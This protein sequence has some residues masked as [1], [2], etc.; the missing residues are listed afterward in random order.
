MKNLMT[1]IIVAVIVIMAVVGS[2]CEEG[3]PVVRFVQGMQL[4]LYCNGGSLERL[5]V[6]DTDGDDEIYG[7]GFGYSLKVEADGVPLA[8]IKVECHVV[9]HSD[10]LD[11]EEDIWDKFAPNGE[12]YGYVHSVPN[13]SWDRDDGIATAYTN[14]HGKCIFLIGLGDPDV[15]F[16]EEGNVG[17]LWPDGSAG[18]STLVEVRFVIKRA[19]GN[20][21]S[22]CYMVFFRSQYQN[23]W[24]PYGGIYGASFSTLVP[25]EGLFPAIAKSGVDEET[26][27]GEL[28]LSET[29]LIR[30]LPYPGLSFDKSGDTSPLDLIYDPNCPYV[31]DPNC[32]RPNIVNPIPDPNCP[33]YI[34]DPDCPDYPDPDC[35]WIPDPNC[36]IPDP[37]CWIPDSAC[38]T[39]F[40]GENDLPTSGEGWA[41]LDSTW[42]KWY[43]GYGWWYVDGVVATW[44]SDID[45]PDEVMLAMDLS[46][47]YVFLCI[48][49]V[50]EVETVQAF[51]HTGTVIAK[52]SLGRRVSELPIKLYAYQI[53][54]NTV[55][56]ATDFILPMERPE[57]QGV[58][59]DSWGDSYAAIYVPEGGHLEVAKD[60][61]YGDFN[62]D[63][64]VDNK[65][66]GL[67]AA[68]WNDDVFGLYDPNFAYDLMYDADYDGQTDISDLIEFMDNW[69]EIR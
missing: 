16:G 26:G 45:N 8:G 64:D 37:N 35:P 11:I 53:L 18:V 34:I 59:Y 69:L 25:W 62:F 3:S 1:K 10:P 17:Y 46:Q 2:G 49:N 20:I 41:F 65:D 5:D 39:Y 7:A 19:S 63:G 6:W 15:G 44:I 55:Y 4:E 43:P 38:S 66:Y 42:R 61:F 31:L 22:D 30:K 23:F 29:E 56:L 13:G 32:A 33:S 48:F 27:T 40:E 57:Q 60:G 50:N 14:E 24:E 67:F 9:N 28:E 47:P 68:R 21:T 54:G 12:R 36:M 52:D 58:Y 51:R